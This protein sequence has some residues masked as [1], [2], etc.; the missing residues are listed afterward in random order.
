ML[1]K[2]NS[3][4]IYRR[5]LEIN[6]EINLE[7]ANNEQF[8]DPWTWNPFKNS[9]NGCNSCGITTSKN[10]NNMPIVNKVPISSSSLPWNNMNNMNNMGLKRDIIKKQKQ[11]QLKQNTPVK[12]SNTTS[13]P[14][15]ASW[16]PPWDLKYIQQAN[17][18]GQR[19]CSCGR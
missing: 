5:N 19:K 7:M 3:H 13:T 2:N 4:V 12:T 1:V 14:S 9:N 17:K 16:I 11:Q 18:R 15:A 8:F 10:N 6:L